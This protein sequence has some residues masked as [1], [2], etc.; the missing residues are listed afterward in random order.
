MDIMLNHFLSEH[1]RFAI[2]WCQHIRMG[3]V[4]CLARHGL[5]QMKN[6]HNFPESARLHR[7]RQQDILSVDLTMNPRW[8]EKEDRSHVSKKDFFAICPGDADPYSLST[9]N[10]NIKIHAVRKFRKAW[11][12][13]HPITLIIS[14]RN[15]SGVR[16]VRSSSGLPKAAFN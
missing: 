11:T 7:L 16:V 14:R 5:L 10:K 3:S 8:S 6:L 2:P 1:D 12:R 4:S 9:N 13:S 15:R